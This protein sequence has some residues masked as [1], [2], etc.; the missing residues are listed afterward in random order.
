MERAEHRARIP[1]V[2][3]HIL[4]EG[5][6]EA[7]RLRW[8]PLIII[9]GERDRFFALYEDA[10]PATVF[11]F[12]AFRADN[13]SSITR[14]V[15][16]A[17]ENARTIRDRLSRELWED[18]NGLYLAVTR[19]PQDEILTAGPHRF[20]DLVKFGSHRVQGVA[21]ATRAPDD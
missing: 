16:W 14:C 9:T 17:R 12:L 8:E 21:S 18:I 4:L 7:S 15:A 2:N 19:F 1:D 5:T 11:D 10:T 13:P 6:R 20:C 3:S